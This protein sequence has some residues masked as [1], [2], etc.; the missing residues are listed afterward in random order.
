M[1]DSFLESCASPVSSDPSTLIPRHGHM[2]SDVLIIC[3]F[4]FPAPESL[5]NT[6]KCVSSLLSS[7]TPFSCPA[8][9]HHTPSILK[10]IFFG[11]FFTLA[12]SCLAP[13]ISSFCYENGPLSSCPPG[14]TYQGYPIC[15]H[16]GPFLPQSSLKHI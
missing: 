4:R 9:V 7:G 16:S 2:L 12:R 1:L 14:S 6:E 5:A 3:H 13:P 8:R 15:M 11:C 10:F